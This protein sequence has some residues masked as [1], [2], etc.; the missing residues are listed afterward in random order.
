MFSARGGTVD[1]LAGEKWKPLFVGSPL[2]IP[3][4]HGSGA[5]SLAGQSPM[6]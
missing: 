1:D 5:E 4:T 3:E 6:S 2:I